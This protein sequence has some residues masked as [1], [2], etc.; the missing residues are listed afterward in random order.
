SHGHS[1]A[2]VDPVTQMRGLAS[3]GGLWVVDP[4]CTETARLA[5]RHLAPR[6]GTDVAVVAHLVREL[7]RDGA[8]RASLER[9]AD[10]VRE[11]EHAVAPFTVDAVCA[12]TGLESDDLSSLVAAVRASRRVTALSGTGVTM[13]RDGI[14]T[15]WL[16]WSLHVVTGS[17]EQPGG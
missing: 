11:L 3:R 17:W 8:D 7:L 13:S 4:V 14:L 5:T 10:G 16:L 2:V 6:A 12:R 1:S 15:E 9:Y